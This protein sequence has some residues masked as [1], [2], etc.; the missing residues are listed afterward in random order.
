MESRGEGSAT[1]RGRQVGQ[2]RDHLLAVRGT[3]HHQHPLPGGGSDPGDRLLEQRAAGAGQVVQELRGRRPRQRPQPRA[4]AAGR[5]DGPEVVDRRHGA[6]PRVT[7]LMTTFPQVLSGLLART[8]AAPSSPS[9]TT[10]PVSGRSCRSR[11]TPTGWRRSRRCS[12]TSS[13]SS[14]AACGRSTSPPT[15]SRRWCSARP[16]PAGSR[17]CGR[18]RPTSCSPDR[19]A[20]TAGPARRPGAGGRRRAAAARGPVRRA[21]AGRRARSRRGGLV[22]AR[23]VRRVAGSHGRRPGRARRH[24]GGAVESGRRRESVTDGGRLLSET[25]PASPSGLAS[26]TEPLV[27][28]VPWSWSLH[29]RGATRTDRGRRTRHRTLRPRQPARS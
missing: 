13:R 1:T 2:L 9:T 26:F 7:A 18:A 29:A 16:G 21:A 12:S 20:S 5:H 22:A 17:W 27:A 19:T 14:T 11:R 28:A 4:G 23:R 8:P 6:H 24:P 15:G 3:G 25:S 10:R